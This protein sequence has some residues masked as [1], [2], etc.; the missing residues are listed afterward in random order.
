MPFFAARATDAYEAARIAR[1]NHLTFAGLDVESVERR[2]AYGSTT[3]EMKFEVTVW[4]P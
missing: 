4:L 1:E 2:A 3:Y